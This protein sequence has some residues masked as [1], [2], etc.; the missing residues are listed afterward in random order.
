[1]RRLAVPL[2]LLVLTGCS[3]PLP[4]DVH[5]VGEVP[6]EQ[7]QAGALQVI[8][9]GPKADATPV[10]MVLGFLG[11]QASSDGRHAIARQFLSDRER[12]RW[13]DDVEVQVYDPDRLELRQVSGAGTNE[14]LVRVVTRVSGRVRAD[15]SFVVSPDDTVTEDY[16]LLRV[17]GRW[18]LDDV[19]E[20]LRLTAADRQ[21][22]FA[23]RLVYYLAPTVAGESPHLVPDQVFLPVGTDLARNLVS[24]LLRPPSEALAGSVSTAVPTGTRLSRVNLSSS[25]VVNVD[26]TGPSAPPVGQDAQNLSAQLVWTLRSLGASFRG[27]RLTI[28]GRALAVPGEGEVQ[29]SG[30]WAAYDPQGLG[31]A[32]PYF[33]VSAR[34]LRA[35]IV[36]PPNAAT[37][38][39][40]GDGRAVAVDEVAVTPDRTRVGLVERRAGGDLVRIGA[41]RGTSF[42]VVAQGVGLSSPTWGSGQHGLWLLRGESEVVR[43]D[44][45]LRPVTVLGLPAGR[46]TGLAV[47]RDGARAA[48]VAGGRLYVGRVELVT[49]GPRVVGLTLVLAALHN[50]TRVAWS[51]STEL[52][53]LG[54]LTRSRQVVRLSVDGSSLQTVNTSGLVPTEIAASPVGVV[55]LAGG[56]L[57]LSSGGSFRQVQTDIASDPVFPG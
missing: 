34:R 49:G 55:L 39:D 2:L 45:G 43:V 30:E 12:A 54:V 46:L 57:Y 56:R 48:L 29:Q 15:G 52:V 40:V 26:L 47:S 23:P 20:G 51:S 44:H 5:T 9:P 21:R 36:L 11:A 41:L 13:R 31:P 24:R 37:S 28:D 50:A 4:R 10:E 38:G 53:V 16:R 3:L 25:G 35:S 42:P 7:R 32:P 8:P 18:V 33:F 6:A 19:P 27:L 1:M 17:R 14:A 22:A